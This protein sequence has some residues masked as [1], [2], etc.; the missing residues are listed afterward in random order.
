MMR[1]TGLTRT[2]G[3]LCCTALFSL[4]EA[5]AQAGEN[6][7]AGLAERLGYPADARLL[8]VHADDLGAAHSINAASIRAF[9]VG[10]V[11][12]GSVMVPCPWFPEIAAYARAHP[13]HDLG[14]HL[15]L[16]S[17]WK[18]YR[19]RGVLP[20]AP[21]LY[22]AE[23]FLPAT[24]DAVAA[25]AD[26]AEAEAEI[27]AQVERALAFGL[28][29]THLD[30]HMGALFRTPALFEAYLRVGRAYRLPVFVP[31]DVLEQQAPGLMARLDP[32]VVPVDRLVIAAPGLPAEGWAAFYTRAIEG[33][34]PGLT[35]IIVHLAYDDEEMRAVSVDHPDYGAAW[36]Q[37][38]LDFFTS[39]ATADLLARHN[40]H[41]VTWRE[42]GALLRAES[43]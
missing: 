41:L 18:Y 25:R 16:T 4:P 27:R 21:S 13:G 8:I 2:V 33:L 43:R 34:T 17:E 23:G 39:P 26:P 14:L 9:E 22:D 42:I 19:W 36:R 40:V 6:T 11:T 35:E 38:D 10:L 20:D 1:M 31:R 24:S 15:T 29:P 28:Q 32:N 7:R 5:L 30:S 12:S 37:R 3:M